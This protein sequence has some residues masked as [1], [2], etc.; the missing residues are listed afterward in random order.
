MRTMYA[1]NLIIEAREKDVFLASGWH[2]LRAS[3]RL[4]VLSS[5][6][7][8]HRFPVTPKHHMLFHI[9]HTVGWMVDVSG[10]GLNPVSESCAMDE[11]FIGHLC[12][13]SRSVS[14]RLA[15]LRTVERY[16]L[17]CHDVWHSLSSQ[18]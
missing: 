9:V 4:A 16:R 17:W 6:L 18:P 7:H 10:K 8:E 2:L 13:I 1:S 14:P 15:C 5:Q 3:A 11:D 12:R